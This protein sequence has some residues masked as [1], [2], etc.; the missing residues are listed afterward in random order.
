MEPFGTVVDEYDSGRLAYP[1]LYDD[2][3]P[4][5]GMTVLERGGRRQD[6][7]PRVPSRLLEADWVEAG[8]TMAEIFTTY[9]GETSSRACGLWCKI[10][11]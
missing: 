7:G 2:L 10:G 9:A 11:P 4:L 8:P 5:A 1:D 3:E 6:R